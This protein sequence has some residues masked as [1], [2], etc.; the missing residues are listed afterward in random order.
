MVSAAFNYVPKPSTTTLDRKE[1]KGRRCWFGDVIECHTN[2]LAATMIWRK[3]VVQKQTEKRAVSSS[4]IATVYL[5][6]SL[7]RSQGT[8]GRPV[9][10]PVPPHTSHTAGPAHPA[11]P[12][13]LGWSNL[14]EEKNGHSASCSKLFLNPNFKISLWNVAFFNLAHDLRKCLFFF[15]FYVLLKT[16]KAKKTKS[17]SKNF[18]VSFDQVKTVCPFFGTK[19]I[20]IF[21]LL[22]FSFWRLLLK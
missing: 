1:G 6:Q 4:L 16:L 8:C 2:H 17:N 7:A 22:Q 21:V 5:D 18:V 20:R 15:I 10:W 11:G 3:F 13:T 19:Q 14:L 9:S 12:C